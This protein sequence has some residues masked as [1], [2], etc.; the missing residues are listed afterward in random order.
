[1]H[2]EILEE[3]DDWVGVQVTDNNDVEHKI[4]VTFG[5][6]IQGHS[7]E[8]YS[9][10]PNKRT[11]EENEHVNQARR[12]AK[13]YVYAEKGYDTA[14]HVENPDY[15]N[16][17][18]E[19]IAAL[20]EEAF[21]EYFGALHQQIRSHHE[22]VERLVEIP[23]AAQS[24]DAVVY[25]LDAYLGVDIAES[26]LTEDA[27]S[28]AEEHDLDFEAGT[29]RRSGTTIDESERSAWASFDEELVAEADPADIEYE[30]SAV[31]GIHVG[32]PNAQGQHE[33][34]WAERPVD[35]EPDARIEIMPVEP[36]PFEE[37]QAFLDHHLRCQIRDCFVGMGLVPPEPFQVIGFGKFIYARR[38]DHYDLY[39]Q[40]HKRDGDHGA[41]IK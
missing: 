31:S 12:F 37:F 36:G 27:Q 6:D 10:D 32:F 38:Y 3:T 28:L 5:G 14:E 35:R 17:V 1:M 15:V 20:D 9:D 25:K 19:A 16:A 18:R 8:G 7:Q 39:P 29:T 22:P 21:A 11:E 33:D 23:A 40:L 26:G 41:V 24:E 13:Y 2:A 34:V 4:A 30:V